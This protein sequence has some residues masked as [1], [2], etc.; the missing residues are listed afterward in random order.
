[1][2]KESNLVD[3]RFKY[4]SLTIIRDFTHLSTM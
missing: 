4:D 1:L 3:M 2:T